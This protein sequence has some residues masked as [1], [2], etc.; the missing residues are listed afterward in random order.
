MTADL[1]GLVGLL[2]LG[3][4]SLIRDHRR[5]ALGARLVRATPAMIS[6]RRRP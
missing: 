1:V 5:A 4:V 2:A 3:L 6:P